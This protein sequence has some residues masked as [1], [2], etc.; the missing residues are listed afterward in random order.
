MTGL[1]PFIVAMIRAPHAAL[2]KADPAK[3]AAK[4]EIPPAFAEFYLTHWS[5]RA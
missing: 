3:L 1:T 2:A 4:Y 5:N